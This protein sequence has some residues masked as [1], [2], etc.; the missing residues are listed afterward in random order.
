M[1]DVSLVLQSLIYLISRSLL[2]PVMILLIVLFVWTLF[3][4]GG[5]VYEGVSRKRKPSR[6]EESAIHA[7]SLLDE[8]RA[9]AHTL[10]MSCNPT[11]YV[12]EFIHD[13]HQFKPLLD[14]RLERVR[15]EKLLQNYNTKITKN[16]ERA[17]I[18]ARVGPMLGLMG[19]LIP[20]GPALLGLVNGDMQALANNLII[21]FGTTVLGICAGGVGYVVVTIRSRWYDQDMSDIEYLT[22]ILYGT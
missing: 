22:E 21:A 8:N 1:M 15:I 10:L 20:M 9:E 2:Y 4:L 3:E 18:I 12:R 13:I 11:R 7:R 19:T 17:G 6:V 16:L 5:F 14:I